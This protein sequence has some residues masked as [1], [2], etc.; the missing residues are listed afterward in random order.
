VHHTGNRPHNKSVIL[1]GCE[2]LRTA[3]FILAKRSSPAQQRAEVEGPTWQETGIGTSE[4][5]HP[6]E[7][8]ATER[9]RFNA[10]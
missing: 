10:R 5:T 6:P 2:V 9:Q 4:F 7:R 1:S 3:D 8:K